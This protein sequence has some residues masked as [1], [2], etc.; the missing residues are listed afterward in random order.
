[1]NFTKVYFTSY[2]GALYSGDDFYLN[3]NDLCI[4]HSKIT[5]LNYL[6]YKQALDVKDYIPD[7]M[8]IMTATY[9]ANSTVIKK[10]K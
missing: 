8:R 3:S 10:L 7:F 6:I 5:P 9:K 1:M 4:C 2:P